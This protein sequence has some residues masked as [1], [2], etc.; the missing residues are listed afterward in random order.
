MERL[1]SVFRRDNDELVKE[2]DLGNLP[3]D[4]LRRIFNPAADDLEMHLAYTI[5]PKE[6]VQLSEYIKHV[7]DFGSYIY[8]L[9]CFSD[10]P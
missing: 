5:T 1:I 6:A 4:Q 7:F 8:Q 9:D 10:A 2:I 3:L